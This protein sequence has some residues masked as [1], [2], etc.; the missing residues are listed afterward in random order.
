M[1]SEEELE[2]LTG[3][4]VGRLSTS[5]PDGTLQVNPVGFGVNRALGSIDIGG[6]DMSRSRK[7]RNVLDNGRAAFV[8]DDVYSVDPW[9]VRFL[10]IRGH[11]E[12]IGEPADAQD[13]A[14]FGPII[15]VHP[16]RILSLGLHPGD[17]DDSPHAV[18]IRSRRAG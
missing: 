4:W 14:R 1:F 8:V 11:A 16:E 13:Q 9:R 3:Q 12:A 2:Y 7:Y 10:E 18:G 6:Y 17:L 15:R 5:Q